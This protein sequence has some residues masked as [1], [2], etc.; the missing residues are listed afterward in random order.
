MKN[1]TLLV[2]ILFSNLSLAQSV[3]S[4]DELVALNKNIYTEYILNHN[5]KPFAQAAKGDFVLITGIGTLETKEQVIAGVENLNIS[6]LEVIS[7]DVLYIKNGAVIIGTL[8]MKGTV[9]GQPIPGK[10]RFSS[11]F[12]KEDGKWKLQ[13]RTMTPVRGK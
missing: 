3:A 2:L 12:V 1:L 11:V 10:M 7:D 4:E 5:T 9:M 8:V 13:S 6:S